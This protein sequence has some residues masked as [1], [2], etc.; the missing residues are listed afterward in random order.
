MLAAEM[1]AT[2]KAALE[3]FRWAALAEQ[4]CGGARYEG[5]RLPAGR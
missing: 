3:C 2:H 4:T 1:V 5:G